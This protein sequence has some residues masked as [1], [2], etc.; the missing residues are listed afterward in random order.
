M[1]IPLTVTDNL[2][3]STASNRGTTSQRKNGPH[4]KVFCMQK[5]DRLKKKLY[6]VIIANCFGK[7]TFLSSLCTFVLAYVYVIPG[8]F[9]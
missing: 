8:V 1:P 6:C 5:T 2:L 4:S 7:Y 9:L 3:Y